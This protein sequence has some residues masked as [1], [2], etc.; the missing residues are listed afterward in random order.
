LERIRFDHITTKDKS[1]YRFQS[2]LADSSTV[3]LSNNTKDIKQQVRREEETH[4][5]HNHQKMMLAYPHIAGPGMMEMMDGGSSNNNGFGSMN[6]AHMNM[7]HHINMNQFNSY[8][9]VPSPPQTPH[10]GSKRKAEAQPETNERLHKRMSRLNLEQSGAKLYVP[11]ENPTPSVPLHSRPTQYSSPSPRSQSP[12]DVMQLDDT[13]HKVYIYNLDDELSSSESEAEDG[14][15]VF[16]PDIEKH[17]LNKRIPSHVLNAPSPS[18]GP[19]DAVEKQMQMVLYSVP[20]SITVPEEQDSVR[21]AIL[22]ARARARERQQGGS[23]TTTTATQF[24]QGS[25][26]DFGVG[27]AIP[28]PGAGDDPDAMELD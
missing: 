8:H 3:T 26:I 17:L 14:K 18:A 5:T 11:V 27:G 23:A 1:H 12:Q 22:E 25:S 13:K 16:L 10:A 4:L 6:H 9:R 24:P 7:N 19:G 21:K 2:L 20:S 28:P 15:L